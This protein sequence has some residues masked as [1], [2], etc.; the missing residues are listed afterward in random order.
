MP[1]NVFCQPCDSKTQEEIAEYYKTFKDH[2]AVMIGGD[3]LYLR[4][5]HAFG[6]GEIPPVFAF[7]RGVIGALLPF[8]MSAVYSMGNM[9]AQGR[10]EWF[11][12]HRLQIT[13]HGRFIG[14]ELSLYHP[15]QKLTIFKLWINELKIEIGRASGLIVSTAAGSMGLNAS[16]GGPICLT[17]AIVINLL[18]PNRCNW[19][20]L[21]LDFNAKIR[22]ET[23]NTVGWIDGNIA[24]EGEIYEI[25]AG[26]SYMVA[27]DLDTDP[28]DS[29]NTYLN[30]K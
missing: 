6:Y 9:I 5:L 1:V 24:V 3:V 20:P 10:V 18:A 16:L 4:A 17:N 21:V 7:N 14:N 13:N 26:D 27:R 2:C 25:E 8:R 11:K 15:K 30:I 22:I 12:R 28:H 19:R 29:L 23:K